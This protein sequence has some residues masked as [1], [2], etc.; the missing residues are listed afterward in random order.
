MVGGLFFMHSCGKPLVSIEKCMSVD[1]QKK[2]I[3][4]PRK[5]LAF[6]CLF[7]KNNRSHL[8]SEENRQES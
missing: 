7:T 3:V 6:V 4:S 1:S 5:P 2:T 8:F